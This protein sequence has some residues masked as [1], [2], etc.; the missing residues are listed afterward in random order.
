MGAVASNTVEN[1]PGAWNP[2]LKSQIPK[3]WRELETIFRPEN[4]YSTLAAAEELRGLTGFGLSD[5]AIF[6]P[7]DWRCTNF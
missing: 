6:R 5:L 1:P 2:G 4:N 7:N 3:E